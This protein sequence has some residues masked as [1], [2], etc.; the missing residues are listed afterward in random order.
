[1]KQCVRV[2]TLLISLVVPAASTFAVGTQQPGVVTPGDNPGDGQDC[3][4]CQ[5]IFYEDGRGD[6]FCR[7][8]FEGSM[9]HTECDIY[10]YPEA[11]YC[12]AF[13]DNCC[14]F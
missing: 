3:A 9:G 13:G 8:P 14:E 10:D 2:V 1:M 6:V 12:M 11:K 5:I 7:P 4:Q